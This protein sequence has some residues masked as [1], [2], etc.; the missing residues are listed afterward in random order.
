MAVEPGGRQLDWTGAAGAVADICSTVVDATG[1]IVGGTAVA[2]RS[3]AITTDQLRAVPD[4]IG[5]AGRADKAP[6]IAAVM[7][8]GLLHRLITEP[9]PP[10]PCCDRTAAV[11]DQ[12]GQV[13]RRPC[14]SGRSRPAAARPHRR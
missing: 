5:L 14:G 4:L 9:P 7:K 8:A 6:V 2:D 13:R 11:T 1:A 10:R 12:A 3:I